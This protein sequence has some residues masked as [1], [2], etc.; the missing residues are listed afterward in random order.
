MRESLPDS[1]GI[2]FMTIKAKNQ[3]ALKIR[4]KAINRPFITK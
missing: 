3:K 2:P 1:S 4:I